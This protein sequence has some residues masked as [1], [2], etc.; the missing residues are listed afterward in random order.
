MGE[1]QASKHNRPDDCFF[2]E[3]ISLLIYE[4]KSNLFVLKNPSVIYAFLTSSQ[5]AGIYE[6]ESTP[7]DN[8]CPIIVGILFCLTINAPLILNFLSSFL[9]DS[10]KT[11]L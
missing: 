2:L 8:P 4:S 7:I 3:E 9:T 10:G 5:S 6:V 11:I 1:T